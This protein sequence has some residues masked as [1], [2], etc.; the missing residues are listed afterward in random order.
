MHGTV[1]FSVETTKHGMKLSLL[2]FDKQL[3]SLSTKFKARGFRD[4]VSNAS[5]QSF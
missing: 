1:S 5:L 4:V 3:F 2:Q